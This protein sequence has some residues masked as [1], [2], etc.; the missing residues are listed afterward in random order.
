MPK[1]VR[2]H[3]FGGPEVLQIEE[4]PVRHPETGEVVI[5]V[6][7]VGL[8]RAESMYYRG[9]YSQ[10]PEFPS[11]LGYEVVGIVTAVGEGVGSS[12]IGQRVGTIP[13]YSMNRY[14]VLGERAVVPAEAIAELPAS[15][16]SVEGAAVWMQ[17]P[18]AYGA[19]VEFA[20]VG[21]GDTVLLTAAS[22]SV[23]LAAI[24]V[25]RAQ[26]AVSIATTRTSA[27]KQ[28]LLDFGADNVI[29]TQEEDL[30]ARV[31]EITDGKLARV[32]FDAVGGSYIETLAQAVAPEGTIYLYGLLSEEANNYPTS[33]FFKSISLTGYMMHQVKVPE[34]FDRMKR[35][36]YEH[37]ANGS[38]K[39]HVDRIFPFEQAADAYRYLESNQQVGKVVITL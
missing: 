23:G 3:R 28:L 35:Y 34:R 12:L 38:F 39:P 6:A 32:A 9:N 10:K 29:A 37:L 15:L 13:I 24:Q 27:K 19:L 8:N 16:S 7:A 2:F 5:N 21:P 36:V 33:A 20:K 22:S 11:G 26:G 1:A 4:V 30:P 17:Y 14:P 25:V 31:R 18:T